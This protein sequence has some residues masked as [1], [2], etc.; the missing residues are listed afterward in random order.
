MITLEDVKKN[1]IIDTYINMANVHL[2]HMGFTE[3]GHRH[4]GLVSNMA[5]NVL[6]FLDYP[7]RE[8]E[9]AAI[10]GYVHDI[11][12]VVSREGHG[13]TSAILCFKILTDMGMPADEVATVIGAI[14]NHEESYGHP[15]SNVSAALILADKS[16]VHRTR[17]KNT[18]FATF[19]IHDRVNYA[20]EKSTLVVNKDERSVTLDLSI[21]SSICPVMEYFEIFL[22]RMIMCRR[23]A[24]FLDCKF[25]IEING[26]KM[27]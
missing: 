9:L 2:G 3:H 20:V 25:K 26:V 4:A 18:D 10:A 22:T 17:V 5:R 13:Q 1:T 15:V 27:L 23:A 21:D 11:G 6:R 14:G 24:E 8:Q 16:D 19:D 7:E 12:N